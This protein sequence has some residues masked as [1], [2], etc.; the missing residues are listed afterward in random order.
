MS[1]I[2]D[3]NWNIRRFMIGGYV[4]LAV[5]VFGLGAW[6]A[7]TKITGAVVVAGTLEVEGNRQVLQHPTG[8]VIEKLNGRDGMEVKKGDVLVELEGDSIVTELGIV[9]GNGT[10]SWRAKAGSRPSATRS[11][12]SPMIRN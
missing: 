2:S 4:V 12:R 1:E 8:G 3:N 10:R 5:M 6:A 9:E 11:R 7:V